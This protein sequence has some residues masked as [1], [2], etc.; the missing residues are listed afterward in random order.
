MSYQ[1]QPQ[2]RRHR[3]PTAQLR[4]SCDACNIAKVKCSK[5]RPRCARCEARNGDCVYS[6]SLRSAKG[7][8]ESSRNVGSS[9]FNEDRSD[10]SQP[11]V[12]PTPMMFP[13]SIVPHPMMPP[14]PETAFDASIID[15]WATN[16]SDVGDQPNFADTGEADDPMM[17]LSHV[18]AENGISPGHGDQLFPDQRYKNRP[19]GLDS[20]YTHQSNYNS[21]PSGQMCSCHQRILAKL[22][23]CWL[24]SR[25]SHNPFDKS[26]SENKNIIA[27]CTSTLNCPNRSHTD[28]T[29]L[30][31]TII[32]L[33]NQMITIY[34]IP[35]PNSY[36]KN[37]PGSDDSPT[38]SLS[39]ASTPS[40]PSSAN[41]ELQSQLLPPPQRV[42]LS[43][44]SY[45]LDQRD[46][47][48]LKAS[49]L[50]IELGKIGTL[51]ELF[52]R[53]FCSPHDWGS[54]NGQGGRGEPKPFGELVTY[55]RKRLRVNHEALRS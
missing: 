6:V 40:N 35:L 11:T 12:P 37:V 39:A 26:L 21:P 23:E 49:L 27:L 54:G 43:L 28:D 51:I 50:R 42:R 25:D 19:T 55:L 44:G 36:G 45:Q 9:N 46:E 13:T 17:I 4:H 29:I 5:T 31:L 53:R 34:D 33:I 48:I 41:R 22:S 7:R 1:I 20:T 2:H 10:G 3:S 30:M 15:G 47:Q 8:A 16:F 24:S 14:L 52:E 18:Y 38:D 32:A